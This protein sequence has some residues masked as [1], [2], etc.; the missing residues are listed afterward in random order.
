MATA[1]AAMA[2]S[3]NRLPSLVSPFMATK[4]VP[5]RT[6]RE[7]YSTPATAAFPLWERTSAPCRSC[8][9]VI[10][11]IITTRN[12]AGTDTACNGKPKVATPFVAPTVLR[13]RIF[14]IDLFGRRKGKFP[15]ANNLD[16]KAGR[17]FHHVL[18]VGVYARS[19]IDLRYRNNLTIES[20]FCPRTRRT[21][22]LALF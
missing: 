21:A 20:N 2:W 3:M 14:D 15:C 9:N 12:Y 19:S 10:G 4:T 7:S 17:E 1:P 8:W 18:I 16:S 13:L 22:S 5:G 11:V 6:R